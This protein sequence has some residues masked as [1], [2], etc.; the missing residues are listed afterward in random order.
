MKNLSISMNSTEKALGWGYYA[1]QLFLLQFIMTFAL[2]LMRI[3]PSTLVFNV[4]YFTINF[5]ATITIYHRFLHK[6]IKKAISVLPEVIGYCVMGLVA[7]WLLNTVVYSIILAVY[8]NYFNM[9][10]TAISNMGQTNFPLLLVGTV[11]LVPVAEE[12]IYRGLMFGCLYNRSK[13][14]AYGVSVAAFSLI[15]IVGYIPDMTPLHFAMSFVQYLP[16]SIALA[17]VYGKTDTIIT[18]IL[19]HMLI[20]LLGIFAVR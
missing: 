9:N 3:Y 12:M 13:I 19:M 15:H 10:N 14:L 6:S 20:N 17:W 2:L 7:Y 8:P 18:P 1:F 4:I 11:F 5:L 16:A